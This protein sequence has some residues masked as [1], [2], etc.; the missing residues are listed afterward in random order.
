[1]NPEPVILHLTSNAAWHA[2]VKQGI[3]VPESLS[4][5]GFIH[6]STVSQI[7]GVANTFYR[8]QPGLVLLVIEPSE[9][10][11]ELK[12]E[13]SAEPEPSHAREGELFPHL[14][15]PLNTEAVVKALPFEP[16]PEGLFSLPQGL[17]L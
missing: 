13:P 16:D 3:Y 4:A 9:L 1:M 15:G 8:G 6:C 5:E 10:S 11:A 17:D 2:A 14:Y 7:V 12:W